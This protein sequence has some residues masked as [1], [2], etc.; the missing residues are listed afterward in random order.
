MV[1]FLYQW[2]HY[3]VAQGYLSCG[4]LL[5]TLE[6]KTHITNLIDQPWNLGIY[7]GT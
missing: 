5:R 3:H 6:D 2:S 1:I 7:L 4:Y